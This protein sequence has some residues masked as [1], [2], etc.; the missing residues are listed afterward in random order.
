[1]RIVFKWTMQAYPVHQKYTPFVV[2]KWRRQWSTISDSTSLVAINLDGQNFDFGDWEHQHSI[3]F[4][5][6]Q[7]NGEVYLTGRFLMLIKPQQGQMQTMLFAKDQQNN[8]ESYVL[9]ADPKIYTVI[10][11]TYFIGFFW[12]LVRLCYMPEGLP[13]LIFKPTVWIVLFLY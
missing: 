10:T 9:I 7:R 11:W 12:I 3:L 13:L 1:M 2:S 6:N 4:A 5:A 8:K